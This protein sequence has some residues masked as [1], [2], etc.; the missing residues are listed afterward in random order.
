MI[1]SCSIDLRIELYH[2][3]SLALTSKLPPLI[4]TVA[5]KEDLT[6]TTT[7]PLSHTST[8]PAIRQTGYAA[9]MYQL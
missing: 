4:F 5:V 6:P 1:I 9:E 7:H 8:Q 2:P 3:D